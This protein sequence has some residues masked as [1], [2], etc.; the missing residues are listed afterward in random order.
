MKNNVSD[1]RPD[2]QDP[3][4]LVCSE[5]FFFDENATQLC[6]PICGEFNRLPLSVQIVEQM[7]VCICFIG[8]IMLFI[9]ALT[10][11][12]ESL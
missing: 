10:V 6:R 4:R 12:R 9:M 7:C 3:K 2:D 11:Q 8:S 5:G 1:L